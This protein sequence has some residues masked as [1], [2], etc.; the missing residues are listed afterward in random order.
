[1]KF[2]PEQAMKVQR[3]S[4]DVVIISF[5]TSALFP[6]ERDPVLILLEAGWEQRQAYRI[7]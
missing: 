1:V 6:R 5:L 2:I 3:R 4:R 7:A